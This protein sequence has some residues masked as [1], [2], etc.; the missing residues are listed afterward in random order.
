M[1]DTDRFWL[2]STATWSL[3][4]WDASSPGLGIW[5]FV[6]MGTGVEDEEEGGGMGEVMVG[7]LEVDPR[8][9]GKKREREK[10]I[11]K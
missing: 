6:G 4:S 8:D 9:V 2:A 1:A 3:G 11:R 10:E 5:G 7:T